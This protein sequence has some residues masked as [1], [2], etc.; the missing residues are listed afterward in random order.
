MI[1]IIYFSIILIGC[2]SPPQEGIEIINAEKL[3]ELQKAGTVVVDIR[4]LKEYDQGHLPG[5][6]HIDFFSSD[7]LERIKEQDTSNPLII[8]C[9]SGGRSRKAAEMLQEA[10]FKLIYD[11]KGG[12]SDWK[13]K[14]LD[15][16]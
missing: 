3:I 16:E 4:T 11:Y 10:G 5:V 2:S 12:F 8:H 13:S 15:I 7:F 6:I 14:G 9:A 1:R